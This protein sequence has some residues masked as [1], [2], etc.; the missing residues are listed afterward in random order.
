LNQYKYVKINKF[1]FILFCF[2]NTGTACNY[3]HLRECFANC[4]YVNG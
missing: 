2:S 4:Q 3:L 1:P